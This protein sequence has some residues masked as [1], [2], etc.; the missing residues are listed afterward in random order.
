MQVWASVM[1]NEA[2]DNNQREPQIELGLQSGELQAGEWCGN[3]SEKGRD[4]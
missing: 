2:R 1:A 4:G 3:G